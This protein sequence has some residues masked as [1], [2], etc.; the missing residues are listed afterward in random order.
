MQKAMEYFEEAIE[1]DPNYAL[2]YAA[3]ADT[4]YFL[5]LFQVMPSK[6]AL[7]KAEEM[8]LKALEIDPSLAEAHAVLGAVKASYHWDWEGAEKELKLAIELDPNSALVHNIYARFLGWRSRFEEAIPLLK[9][10]QQL[11]PL[12][13]AWRISA[14]QLFELARRYDEAIEELEM[15]LAANPN[16]QRAYEVLAGVYEEQ[17]L[18]EKAIAAYQK[19]LSEEEVAGLADAYQTLGKEGYWQWWL[20]HWKERAKQR[21]VGTWI[22]ARI[23]AYLGEKDQAIEQLEKA[24]EEREF[25]LPRIGVTPA[26]APLR[27]DPRFNLEP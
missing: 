3:L 17:G 10:A 5:P 21:Y 15:A 8:A 4:Y 14:A 12:F 26:Y 27:D 24:F 18:Y 22:F 13:L 11:D 9:R 19:T 1:K 16:F 7:P 20:D 2:A 25:D 6:E 23:Y